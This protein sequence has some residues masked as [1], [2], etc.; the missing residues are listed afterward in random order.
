MTPSLIGWNLKYRYRDKEVLH[1]ATLAVR[2]GRITALVGPNGGGKTTLLWTL[3]GLL[4]PAGGKV[5]QANSA[6]T[7][8]AELE[9]AAPAPLGPPGRIGMVFQ[10]S[11]LWE[12]LTVE[13]HL[14]LVL[15]RAVPVRSERRRRVEETLRRM[16]LEGFRRRKPA[17]MSGGERQRLSIARALV[18]EPRWLLLDEPLAHLDGPSQQLVLGLLRETAAEKG[19]GCLMSTHDADAAMS[20]ADEVVV[21]AAGSVLQ[22][23]PPQEVYAHPV[24][25]AA[26]QV[27]GPATEIAGVA[28]NGDL[29]VGQTLCLRGIDAKA[30]GP[31]RLILRPE[32]VRFAPDAS[33]PAKVVRCEWNRGG[34]LLTVAAAETVFRVRSPLPAAPGQAGLLVAVPADLRVACATDGKRAPR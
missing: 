4:A 22:S 21:L 31:A 28:R 32:Q 25:L 17:R 26:A 1:G 5:G 30:D 16:R 14:S 7:G 12:H 9:K 8:P 3:A 11:A 6:P 2:G 20:L 29:R 19:V 33:G 34:W 23:G 24:S 15:S 13:E 18:I 10:Q 27:L